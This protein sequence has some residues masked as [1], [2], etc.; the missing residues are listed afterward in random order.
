MENEKQ[1]DDK[2]YTFHYW[3]PE[4][5]LERLTKLIKLVGEPAA[6]LMIGAAKQKQEGGSIM[7]MD[8][9]I[10][11]DAIGSLAMRLGESEVKGFI[12]ECQDQLLCNNGPIHFNQHYKGKIGHLMKVTLA[13]VRFQFADF[14]EYLPVQGK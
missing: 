6:K 2:T 11:S 1:I 10:A 3:E 13:Q 7:D 9:N 14:L 12:I 4:K 8:M 5:A